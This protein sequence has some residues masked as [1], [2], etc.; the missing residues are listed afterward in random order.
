MKKL[1]VRLAVVALGAYL[2][3]KGYDAGLIDQLA[4]VLKE[5]A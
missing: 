2:A 5:A 3:T 4:A 1:L